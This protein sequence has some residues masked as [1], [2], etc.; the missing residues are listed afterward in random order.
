[1][2]KR[3]AVIG[4][5]A[6]GLCAAKNLLSQ[7]IEP[8]IFEIG[9]RIGGL[10]V[11]NNDSGRSPAYRSLHINSEAKVSSYIDFPFLPDT[12]L[13][14]DTAQME[15]YFLDYAEHFDLIDR[16]RFNSEVKSIEPVGE[17]YRVTTASGQEEEFDGV[18]VASGHQSIPRHPPQIEG[19]TGEYLHS[20]GYRE[21][22]PFAGKRVLVIGPGN[23]GVDVAA[24]IC[25]VTEKTF[26]A[27]RSP[28]L[29]MPRLMFGV[30][31]SRVLVKLEKPWVPW[32]LRIWMRIML[33]RVFHGRMEQWGFRTPHTRTHPISHP[34]LIS[35]IAW[36]RI[37][38]K[39]GI[40]RAEGNAVFFTDGS[41]ETVDSIIA[42]TGYLTDLPFLPQGTSPLDGTRLSLYN[43]VVHPSLP[44]VFF[45]GFFDASGGS[46][47]R[48]MDD[49][50]EYLSTI[51]SGKI[52]LPP[53]DEMLRAIQADH[54]FQ[55]RQFPDRPRY[56]LELDP[57]RYRKALAR[58]YAR[59]GVA[60]PRAIPAT[61]RASRQS[62]PESEEKRFATPQ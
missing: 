57:F 44:N 5:G 23:S 59:S 19:F 33:T 51:A 12:P 3:Y 24:D 41:Q 6:G 16:I 49:Q 58:D 46:N 7:G 45:I 10:W 60:R 34:T 38:V 17:R 43:R 32:S 27:A 9:S 18:V 4:A 22:E 36:E 47:I 52:T 25:T 2:V 39:P 61:T 40:E 8:A 31:Q 53:H 62:A 29:I 1:M 20:H 15:R 42:A 55:E 54:D 56:G 21:P 48:M 26:L 37:K 14:P 35:H 11:Y 28:V 30:P 50:A 13:Y